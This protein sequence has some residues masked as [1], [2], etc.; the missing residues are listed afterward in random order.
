MARV[1]GFRQ[2]SESTTLWQRLLGGILAG[3]WSRSPHPPLGADRAGFYAAALTRGGDSRIAL[4]LL[5]CD[6]E[7][8]CYAA[9]RLPWY[10]EAARVYPHDERCAFFSAALCRQGILTDAETAAQA[11]M[12]LLRPEWKES[13]FWSA[14]SLSPREITEAL[15]RLYAGD[16]QI[17]PA[18]VAAVEAAYH[19]ASERAPER[20]ALAAFLARAYRAADR[21]DETAR[22]VYAVHFAAC[23]DDTENTALLAAVYAQEDR[24]DPVASAVYAH[25]ARQEDPPDAWSVRVARAY[26][27]LGRVDAETLPAFRRAAR[28]VP[29]HIAVA[30]AVAAAASKQVAPEAD[31]LADLEAALDREAELA[32]YFEAQGWLWSAVVGTL[33]LGWGKMGRTDEAARAVYARATQ[34]CSDEKR[35]GIYHARALAAVPEISEEAIVVYERALR[36]AVGDHAVMT[37][38]GHAYVATDAAEGPHRLAAI[39]VWESLYRQGMS[40]PEM[41]AALARAYAADDRVTDV[42]LSLW[43][44]VVE[45]EPRNGK[46]RVRM[47]REFLA[48][49]DVEEALRWFREGAKLCPRDFEAQYQTGTLLLERSGDYAGAE[50]HLQRAVKA[51]GGSKHRDAHFAL[52]EALLAQDKRAEAKAVFQKIVDKLDPNH[53]PSIMRLAKL[54][55]K[56]DEQAVATAE[57]LYEQ[58]KSLEPGRPDT[59]RSLAELYREKGQHAEEQ[60]A[61]ETFLKLSA[62]DPDALRQLADLYIRRGDFLQAEAALRQVIAL[63][64]GDKKLY[65]L[66]GEVMVQAR[67]RA[68]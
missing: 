8:G 51:T 45:K 62:P 29:D 26:L 4:C 6:A 38:L 66:L 32:P 40:W 55:L 23:P 68:A 36:S 18:R 11:Y 25:M 57:A 15:A 35:H 5:W 14:Y 50:K 42:A 21:R 43:L 64:D 67:A 34:A 63:G 10:R 46:L 12:A 65:T 28:A 17:T 13:R 54:N 19:A 52:G 30:A 58:A 37:G 1:P 9:S 2:V 27:S 59:Y 3:R 7:A 56:Y 41:V 20:A 31:T 49:N 24:R 60:Q 39:A 44:Q 22:A 53:T 33:S 61:L 47:A 16:A 48:R